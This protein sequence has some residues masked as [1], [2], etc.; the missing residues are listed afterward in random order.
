[1]KLVE[2]GVSSLICNAQDGVLEFVRYFS[3]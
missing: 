3:D 1:L 2:Q